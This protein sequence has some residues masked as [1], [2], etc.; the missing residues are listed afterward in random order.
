M[1]TWTVKTTAGNVTISSRTVEAETRG[2]AIARALEAGL[3][4]SARIIRVYQD[5]V[6]IKETF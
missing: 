2:A 5:D 4:A 6:E 3:D 1:Q